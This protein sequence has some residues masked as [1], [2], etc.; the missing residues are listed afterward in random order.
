MANDTVRVHGFAELDRALDVV[1]QTLFPMT[2][3][4][5]L[6]AG[7]Q[8]IVDEEKRLVPKRTGQLRDSIVADMEPTNSPE[9]KHGAF[10]VDGMTIYIGPT[11]HKGW[12]GYMVEMGLGKGGPHP[13]V[14]PAVD[15]K[16]KEAIGVVASE[17]GATLVRVLK[18]V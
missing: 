15:N 2:V 9:W 8:V 13:F 5:A 18:T 14:R 11:L 4:R 10:E 3:A 1:G 12:Y 16:G 7:A 17:L 6:K